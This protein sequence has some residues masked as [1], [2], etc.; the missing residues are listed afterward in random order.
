MR[1]LDRA[2]LVVCAVLA[3]L[4]TAGNGQFPRHR[5]VGLGLGLRVGST[6]SANCPDNKCHIYETYYIDQ[7]IDHYSFV[8]DDTYKMR[9]LMAQQYWDKNGGPIFFYTGN[10]GDITWFC[11][12]TGFMWDIAPEFKAMLV[13]AEH[14][15]YGDSLPYGKDSFKDRKHVGYLTSEQALADYAVLIKH[16]KASIPGA[17]N[18][19]VVAF[20]GSY[21]GMLAAW[22]RMKYPDVIVG[23]VAASAPIWQ[24]NNLTNCNAASS[25]V[26]KDFTEV[27]P[28]CSKTIRTSWA[29][30]NKFG[31]T[32]EGR[33][34]L[35]TSLRLCSPVE[36]KYD[37][38][39]IKGWLSETW[40]NLAMVDYPYN[41]SFL[42]PLPAFPI[43]VVCSHIKTNNA[44]GVPL[45]MELGAAVNVYYNHTGSTK[46]FNTSQTATGSL[47]DLGW[48][49]QA[50]TEM[51]LPSCSDGK[52]DMFEPSPWVYK[53]Y[54]K[55]CQEEWNVTPR[56]DW[57]II[58]YW[59]K[60]ISAASNIVF[61][62]G[63]LDPWSGGGVL[64]SISDSLVAVIIPDGAHHL[65]LRSKNT[66]DPPSVTAARNTEKANIKKWIAKA[67]ADL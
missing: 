44:S 65:D 23:S 19:P 6:A 46:C 42:E 66:D 51:V 47:G 32:P 24:L 4:C 57:P 48:G 39:A 63:L 20:G 43:E 49:F 58:Q 12:N 38:A 1:Y 33:E 60:N 25:I 11:E 41:A 50:C 21:G 53:E 36:T 7:K 31:E 15:Y 9:Y 40:F 2:S 13:F 59:G 27:S 22:M 16:I 64:K 56:P 55:S 54:V 52:H 45:L 62:N 35:R 14:R 3:A 26:T 10:E 37:V 18:S 29:T 28:T 67:N 8:S 34:Q 17:A 30:I 61:S 5:P